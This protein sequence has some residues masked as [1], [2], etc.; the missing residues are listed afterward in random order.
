MSNIFTKESTNEDVVAIQWNGYNQDALIESFSIGRVQ[1]WS[2]IV[3]YLHK[4]D[5]YN[6]YWLKFVA[7]EGHTVPLS[8]YDW[9]VRYVNSDKLETYTDDEFRKIFYKK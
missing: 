2:H 5:D 6:N 3:G 1:V 8:Y 9:V 7:D 4:V